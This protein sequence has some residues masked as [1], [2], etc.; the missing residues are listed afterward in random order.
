[1]T[2]YSGGFLSGQWSQEGKALRMVIFPPTDPSAAQRAG[3]PDLTDT[4][5]RL[6]DAQ[7]TPDGQT[8]SLRLVDPPG[9]GIWMLHR[10]TVPLESP[11]RR[12]G[13]ERK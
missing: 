5:E 12:P 4:Q 6:Y 1:M 9:Q 2:H 3:R 10:T 7:L 11:P 8:L 13:R